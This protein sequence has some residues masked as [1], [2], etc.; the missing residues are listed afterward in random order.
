MP[1]IFASR[2]KHKIHQDARHPYLSNETS[3][4]ASPNK[5]VHIAI[6]GAG[7]S[8]LG[9][10]IRLKQHGQH[11]FIV[12]EQATDIGGTWRD[13]TYPGCACDVPS[14]LYSFSFALN[15]DWS[16]SYSSQ[17]EIWG[18]LRR[19]A[20]RF[21][22]LPHIRWNNQLLDATW[23]D[24][25]QR[26][27]ITTTQAQFTTDFLI[28]G[29]GPLSEPSLPS[30][31]GIERFEGILFHSAQWNHDYD[32]TGKRVAVIG[33]GA[34]AV[35]FVP[36]IQPLVER[37]TLFQRTAPW[38]LPR[39]D[40][41]IPSW[42]RFM[43]R[44]FP[45]TQRL[46]RTI[47]YWQRELFVVGFVYQPQRLEEGMK[48]G[49][50]HLARQVADPALRAK[51][52]PQFTLGCKRVLLSDDFYPA[53]SQPNVEVVTGRIRE[54]Q[55]H[56]IIT[57]DGTE[58]EIDAL[59][60]G[61]G[62]HVTDAQLPYCVYGHSG[63]SL[64]ES[65][66]SGPQAYL[67]TAIAGFPNLFLLIG[68]NTGL[69]H[70]SMIFMIESQLNYIIDC[71]RTMRRR[72][73]QTVEVRPEIQKTFNSE[74]QQRMQRTVWTSGCASWYLDARGKNT[75]LWPGFTF[76]FRRRTRHFDARN[77]NLVQQRARP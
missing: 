54:V 58:H 34:S 26:W 31:P 46:A 66:Q 24:D 11:D 6:L 76:E 13:N 18:Y 28:L 7:F 51:L 47:I 37:L 60:C 14:H 32:F 65:W 71:L 40:H 67:G 10:A 55:G 30:I 43:F 22:I 16:R 25:K 75:T 23:S 21:G 36:H 45:L 68:P 9:M 19:C 72:K 42:Q 29:N 15:P 74:M 1:R 38:I 27:H 61:T 50:R 33:T 62:F 73:L 48:I 17:H 8:G 70:T 35:Q 57:E 39:L 56:S 77:Y 3:D 12:I 64:A 49:R 59:I 52:T 53:T 44:L 2:A 20:R 5:H 63:Q 69:G 4:N 41:P